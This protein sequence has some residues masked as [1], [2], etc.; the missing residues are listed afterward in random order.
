MASNKKYI[1]LVPVGAVPHIV[2]RVIAAHLSG[3]LDLEVEILPALKHP[4]YAY[5]QIRCQY[6]AGSIINC[7]AAIPMEQDSKIIGVLDL[8]LFVPLFTHCLGEAQQAGRC[9]VISLFRLRNYRQ[10]SDPSTP[11]NVL[12]RAAKIALHELGHLFGLL[13]CDDH[14]CLMHFSSESEE[15]DRLGFYFCRY[16]VQFIS[17]AIDAWQTQQ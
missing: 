9:A 10:P 6:D 14:K 8:D 16:C 5:H 17:E 13:H 1:N 3:Y 11:P 12:E 4:R 7:L 2:P 15:L